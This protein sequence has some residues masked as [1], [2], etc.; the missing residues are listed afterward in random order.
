VLWTQGLTDDAKQI[1]REGTLLSSD[2]ETLQSTL[3]RF[4]V[5]P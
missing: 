2:N 4:N 5:N 1:W 3:K